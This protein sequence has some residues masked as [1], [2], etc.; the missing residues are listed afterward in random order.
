MCISPLPNTLKLSALSVS[1]TFKL[2]SLTVSRINLSLNCLLVLNFPSVPANG[3]LLIKNIIS[4]DG[5]LI[6]TNGIETGLFLSLTVSPIVTSLLP[7]KQIISPATPSVCGTRFKPWYPKMLTT[8]NVSF[9]S[10]SW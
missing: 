4:T 3:L 9:L 10:V 5:W 7:A 1:Y 2:R 8:L 6:L